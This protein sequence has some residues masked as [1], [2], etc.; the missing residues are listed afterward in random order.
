M[1]AMLAGGQLD[2][3]AGNLTAGLFTA[4]AENHVA[5]VVADKGHI[6]AHADYICLLVRSDHIKSGRFK[7]LKDL[8][9]FKVGVTALDGVSQQIL[10]DRFL[11]KAGLTE[12][13]V[14]YIKLSYSEINA[15][16]KTG[17]LDASIQLEPY[18][19][20]AEIEGFATVAA[21]G[22][23]VYLGQQSAAVIYSHTFLARHDDAVHFMRAYLKGVHDYNQSLHDPILHA[24]VVAVLKKHITLSDEAWN[25]LIPV[26][27]KDDGSIN[28]AS[29]TDDLA[30]YKQKGFIKKPLQFN[31]VV[32]GSFAAEASQHA[33]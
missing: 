28:T 20:Q 24:R 18:L 32:D 33:K 15:A 17:H 1:T 16:L 12:K 3:A 8:K 14:Q 21:K 13:D 10:L 26:G 31:D 22:S 23:E 27:L 30:W 19:T 2:V 11:T 5:T 7:T 29:V 25:R 6:E 4:I 9:G